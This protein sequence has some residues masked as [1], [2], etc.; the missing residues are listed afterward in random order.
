[1]Y[2]Y[3]I[4]LIISYLFSYIAF[5]ILNKKVPFYILSLL[6]IIIPSLLAGCRDTTVGYDIEV[7][8]VPLFNELQNISDWQA[9]LLIGASSGL[10]WFFIIF[11][12]LITRFTDNIFWAFFIQQLIVLILIYFTCYRLHTKLNASF[13]YFTYLLF[14]FCA[15]MTAARQVFAISM[16]FFSYPYIIN[17]NLYKF[18]I[19]II[20]AWTMHSSALFALSLYPISI[21]SINNKRKIDVIKLIFLCVL[22]LLA[23]TYFPV[24]TNKLISYGLMPEKY[25]KYID[26]E[27]M[28]HK[29]DILLVFG[30]FIS[31]KIKKYYII[32]NNEIRIIK[33]F[34]SY[35]S[36]CLWQVFLYIMVWYMVMQKLSH[37]HQKF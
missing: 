33:I 21:Y 2:I 37:I 12:Y 17:R 27:Y 8:M 11:N 29:L 15:S 10:E 14:Y 9:L 7:Y 31:S 6:A 24:I 36:Y 34:M 28:T 26:Q 23:Y 19:C 32:R 16:V 13:L 20:V 1:M 4:I 18:I 25:I 5:N 3:I 22:G 35:A 30:L